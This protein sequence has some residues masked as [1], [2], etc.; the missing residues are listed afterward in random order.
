[1]GEN[2][3]YSPSQVKILIGDYV[4]DDAIS[5]QWNVQDQRIPIYGY[6]DRKYRTT[7]AGRSI[8]QGMLEI[9]FRFFG[10]LTWAMQQ[11]KEDADIL[12]TASDV[13]LVKHLNNKDE[14]L[15]TF[16]NYAGLE[17]KASHIANSFADSLKAKTKNRSSAFVPGAYF[18]KL[19]D[20]HWKR[21][22]QV[23]FQ[24]PG[25]LDTSCNIIVQYGNVINETNPLTSLLIRDVQFVGQSTAIS[26]EVPDGGMPVREAYPFLARSVESYQTYV[27]GHLTNNQ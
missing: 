17:E 22:S 18:D 9:N 24:R 21:E 6:N 19:K 23:A 20:L 27:R 1:M 10:Y 12:E 5:I 15:K 2:P 13:A 3:Y 25:E 16:K 7:V 11:I 4:V 14:S 8:V 26:A